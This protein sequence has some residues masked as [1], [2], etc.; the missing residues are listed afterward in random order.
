MHRVPMEMPGIGR[1]GR[2]KK[3]RQHKSRTETRKSMKYGKRSLRKTNKNKIVK[4][5]DKAYN[6]NNEI[7][8]VGIKKGRSLRKSK[9]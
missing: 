9:E 3:Q 2:K 8:K 6:E 5:N 4:T 1:S 7:Q